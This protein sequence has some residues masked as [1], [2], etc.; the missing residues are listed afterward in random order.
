MDKAVAAVYGRDDL[1]LDHGFR[2]TRQRIRFTIG[3]RARR[4]SSPAC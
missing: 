4:E 2:E 1:D 3:D